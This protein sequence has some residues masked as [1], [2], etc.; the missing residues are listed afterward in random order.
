M[1]AGWCASVIGLGRLL[2]WGGLGPDVVF[3]G[4]AG[5]GVSVVAGWASYFFKDDAPPCSA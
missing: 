4:L 3:L 5:F 2:E 1:S